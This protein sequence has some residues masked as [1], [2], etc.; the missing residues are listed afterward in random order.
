MAEKVSRREIHRGM[1]RNP[2]QR[3]PKYLRL[4]QSALDRGVLKE[5]IDPPKR[6][7]VVEGNRER[8]VKPLPPHQDRPGFFRRLFN[9]KT[10]G[11]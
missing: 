4:E 6:Q 3:K 8:E 10:G 5:Q 1:A 7:M 9:R 2:G 11:S